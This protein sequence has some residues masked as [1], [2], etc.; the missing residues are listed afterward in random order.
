MKTLCFPLR[1]GP[2][3]HSMP[4]TSPPAQTVRLR[5]RVLPET[6]DLLDGFAVKHGIWKY[7]ADLGALLDLVAQKL[8]EF[9]TLLP[10]RKG[11]K[12]RLSADQVRLIRVSGDKQDAI[13]MEYRVDP[14]TI[15]RIRNG[16]AYQ[17]VK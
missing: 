9:T 15:S 4:A 8:D 11:K 6:R 10:D 14:A 13:A 5:V 1:L 17:W 3:G 2:K 12:W 7:K 16:K